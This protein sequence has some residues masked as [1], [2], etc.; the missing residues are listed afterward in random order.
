MSAT[1][2]YTASGGDTPSS[3]VTTISV[4]RVFT[5]DYLKGSS[6]E[7]GDIIVTKITN[8]EATTLN[9]GE[10]TLQDGE[11]FT[12]AEEKKLVTVKLSDS[13]DVTTT[14]Q[15]NVVDNYTST[16][17]FTSGVKEH[18]NNGISTPT[19]TAGTDG[20]YCYF[21]DFPQTIKEN[22]NKVKIDMDKSE[23]HGYYTYY[24]GSDG[25]WYCKVTESAAS[26]SEAYK[27]SNGE[28]VAVATANSE[29]WFKVE[30]IKWR[31]VTNAY[32]DGNS[33]P[34]NRSLLV[35]ENALI[36]KV[37]FC[38][39]T[40]T[41]T[42]GTGTIYPNNYLESRISAFLNGVGYNDGGN[43][44]SSDFTDKGFLQTAFTSD[45][46]NKIF[47]INV[48]NSAATTGN[49]SSTFACNNSAAKIFLLSYSEVANKDYFLDD[50]TRKRVPTDFGLA[51]KCCYDD[52]NKA[53][54]WWLRSP[55]A[56]TSNGTQALAVH[57]NGMIETTG[58]IYEKNVNDDYHGVVPALCVELN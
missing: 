46:Q 2:T 34:Q 37:T 49:S 25:N 52:T 5:G 41:R 23:Q 27:Y 48:D 21:G 30:P 50:E 4:E 1:A 53:T 54:S 43:G 55:G 56:T 3:P 12:Q 33:S 47:E 20:T 51:T 8:G 15:V 40:S 18:K 7:E 31:V 35:A 42:T 57:K 14:F 10:Y 13:S 58:N 22:D 24:C 26:N 36:G 38:N 28:Q 16:Y 29:K 17:V 39:I 19:G 44:G 11:G 32:S 6:I 9:W 45:A